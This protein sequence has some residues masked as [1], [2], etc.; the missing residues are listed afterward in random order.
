MTRGGRKEEERGEKNTYR[1]KA[2]E[3]ERKTE[4]NGQ[5]VGKE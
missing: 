1:K 2:G 4:K 3:R 5:K